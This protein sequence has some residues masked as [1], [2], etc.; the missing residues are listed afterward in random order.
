MSY[1]FQSNTTLE[2]TSDL[3]KTFYDQ[4]FDEYENFLNDFLKTDPSAREM[5]G[6]S[7]HQ[8]NFLDE[9][10]ALNNFSGEKIIIYGSKDQI[11]NPQYFLK[12]VHSKLN[13]PFKLLMQEYS[14]SPHLD[15]PDNFYDILQE[16]INK[17]STSSLFQVDSKPAENRA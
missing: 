9:I 12:E 1:L 14:H 4:S 8:N 7:L 2:Q 16:I 10:E 11:V 6:A 15:N 5:L 13:Q 3:A 17:S